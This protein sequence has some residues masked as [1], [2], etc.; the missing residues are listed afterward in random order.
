MKKEEIKTLDASLDPVD[1][2]IYD[3]SSIYKDLAEKGFLIYN[4]PFAESFEKLENNTYPMAFK[5]N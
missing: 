2:T 3:N 4:I 5:V 1:S